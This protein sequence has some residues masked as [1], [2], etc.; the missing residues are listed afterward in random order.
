MALPQVF[1]PNLAR[2]DSWNSASCGILLQLHFDYIA[3]QQSGPYPLY[4]I[5]YFA[6]LIGIIICL[7]HFGEF[8]NRF[9]YRYIYS[10]VPGPDQIHG[11][12]EFRR[13]YGALFPAVL[14]V[15]FYSVLLT[16]AVMSSRKDAKPGT[17][18]ILATASLAIL[19]ILVY[20][21]VSFSSDRPLR[22]TFLDVCQGDGAV[23]ELPDKR[24]MVVDT[25]KNGFQTANFLRYR[26]IGKIDLL[27]LTHWHPDHCGGLAL[28]LDRFQ[29]REIW[30]NGSM[31]YMVPV[32]A[33]TVRRRCSVAIT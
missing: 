14:L 19:P 1:L 24:V 25:G 8:S 9:L 7:S 10:F 23:V 26:G 32:P 2:R 18:N 21:A 29:I 27:V 4:R 3:P 30:D 28:L 11:N 6:T 15:C 13:D 17:K 33:K 31:T 16:F 5:C 12:M 22:F 20:A